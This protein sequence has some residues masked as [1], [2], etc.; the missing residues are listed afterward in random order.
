[1]DL[2]GWLGRGGNAGRII[3]NGKFILKVHGVGRIQLS[4]DGEVTQGWSTNG[5]IILG[6]WYHVVVT[7]AVGATAPSNFYINGLSN[8]Y[9]ENQASATAG[10]VAGTTNV[11]I[12]NNTGQTATFDGRISDV[13][14]Y[15]RVLSAAEIL[16]IYNSTR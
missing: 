3:A 11:I 9:T 13:R 15:N 16:A 6:K 8:Q 1:M 5:S 2:F 14:V 4:S 10:A 7:R 12:G